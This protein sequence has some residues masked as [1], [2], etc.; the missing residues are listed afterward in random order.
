[1]LSEE[2]LFF[3]VN[4][5]LAGDEIDSVKRDDPCLEVEFVAGPEDEEY[6][7][8]DIGSDECICLE[9]DEGIVTFEE[10]DDC[11]GG[12]GEV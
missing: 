9:G 1:M 11:S 7:K 12:E 8:S 10:G 2:L 5:T 3:L 4:F 6:W